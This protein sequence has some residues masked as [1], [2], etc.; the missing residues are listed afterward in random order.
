MCYVRV[1][2]TEFSTRFPISSNVGSAGN[3]IYTEQT[4]LMDSLGE[5]LV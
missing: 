4:I 5:M 2:T 3:T 1:T